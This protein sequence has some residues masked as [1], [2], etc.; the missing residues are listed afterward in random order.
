MP[1][2]NKDKKN[3]ID[4]LL[5]NKRVNNYTKLLII[6]NT[7]DYFKDYYIPNKKLMNRLKINKKRII[8]L[9]HQLEEDNII[10]LYYKGRK[11]YFVFL[12]FS[13]DKESEVK[14]VFS[15]NND[16]FDYDWLEEEL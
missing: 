11:R 16:V 12:A 8:V 3:I 1:K 15:N 9:L 10:K 14:P 2:K 7:L 6:L 5:N 13:E 4:V